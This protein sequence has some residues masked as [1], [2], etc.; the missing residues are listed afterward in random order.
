MA[1]QY[2]TNGQLL[3]MNYQI[4]IASIEKYICHQKAN[5]SAGLNNTGLI[6]FSKHLTLVRSPISRGTVLIFLPA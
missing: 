4:N 2:I 5:L 1:H 6:S 3:H